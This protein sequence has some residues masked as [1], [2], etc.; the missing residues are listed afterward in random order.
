MKGRGIRGIRG[1]LAALTA[2]AVLAGAMIPA[3]A[4]DADTEYAYYDKEDE[5]VL[6]STRDIAPGEQEPY[7][8]IMS[9]SVWEPLISADNDGNILPCLAQEWSSNEDATEWTFKLREGVTFHD[10]KPFNAEAVISNLERHQ[11]ATETGLSSIQYAYNFGSTYPNY[12]GAEAVDEYT[13]KLTFSESYPMLIENMVNYG[14]PMFSPDNFNEDGTFNGLPMGTGA[15]KLTEHAAD[16]YILLTR[17]DDYY[18][19]KAKIKNI[20]IKVIADANTKVSAMSS[21]EIMGVTDLGAIFPSGAENLLADSEERFAV[22]DAK[23]L[24]THYII[25]NGSKPPFD[26]VRVRQAVSLVIDR[27]AIVNELYAGFGGNPTI[28]LLNFSSPYAKE[29]EIEHDVEKAKELVKEALGDE[30]Y[31]VDIVTS[32]SMANRYPYKEEME[33]MQGWLEEIGI[34]TNIVIYEGATYNEVKAA[35]DYGFSL[36]TRGLS[37]QDP[38]TQLSMFLSSTASMNTSDCLGY[39][40][41][42]AD[43]L[44]DSVRKELD[45]DKRTEMYEQLQD[46]GVNDLPAAP[47]LNVQNYVLYNQKVVTNYQATN[48]GVNLPAIEWVG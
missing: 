46:I 27:D 13:L 25:F 20:R 31:T 28:N 45:A 12:S 48:E 18:G 10:G 39:S 1:M 26:D 2:A 16:E 19:E 33:L 40:N 43:E 36:G 47:I 24:V 11:A 37:T 3:A 7:Y 22:S 35:G 42:E 21:E 44:L 5:L 15:Y 29:Y 32:T 30:E 14:S 41:P 23:S 6:G 8:C 38:Y 34:H 17:N 9:L 4:E